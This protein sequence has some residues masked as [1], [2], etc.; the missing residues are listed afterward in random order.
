VGRKKDNRKE[1]HEHGKAILA[2]DW[3]RAKA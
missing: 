3:A 1:S 2:R